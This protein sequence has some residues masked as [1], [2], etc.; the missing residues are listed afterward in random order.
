MKNINGSLW[1]QK[2]WRKVLGVIVSVMLL[3]ALVVSI[4]L[5]GFEWPYNAVTILLLPLICA[6]LFFGFKMNRKVS[7]IFMAA[8]PAICFYALE[9]YS[10]LALTD[11]TAP[12]QL[13]KLC[14]I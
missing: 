10:H 9:G 13:L 5:E 4:V 2:R 6:A 11:M 3:A 12:I 8:V 1:T 14:L 7:I